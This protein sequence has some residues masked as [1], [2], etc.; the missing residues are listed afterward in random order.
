MSIMVSL[1][2]F[3][4]LEKLDLEV[5]DF[6]LFTELSILECFFTWFFKHAIISV[7]AYF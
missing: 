2:Y 4:A 1:F 6:W 3:Q 7:R 5:F